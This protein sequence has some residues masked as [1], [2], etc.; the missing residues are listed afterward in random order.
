[1]KGRHRNAT[2]RHRWVAL[3]MVGM[4]AGT[5]LI[6]P[7]GAQ[8]TGGIRSLIRN[9]KKTAAPRVA[10]GID[11]TDIAPTGNP[12]VLAQAT[13]TAPKA[14]F[15]ILHG[16]ADLYNSTGSEPTLSCYIRLDATDLESSRRNMELNFQYNSEE[17]C[18]THTVVP[19]QKGGHTVQLRATSSFLDTNYDN[20][21]VSAVWV[22]YGE[23]GARPRNFT[24]L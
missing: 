2:A 23:S 15:L 24:P 4:L 13:I 21:V 5:I 22:P 19:V 12:A 7:V 18:E 8:V 3:V 6:T 16:S 1:V 9:L 20:R 17:N 14:G 10:Y 11:T